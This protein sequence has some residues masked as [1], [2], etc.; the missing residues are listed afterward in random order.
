[1]LHSI[2]PGLWLLFTAYWLISARFAKRSVGGRTR[3]WTHIAIRAT[4]VVL[5]VIAIPFLSIRLGSS[6]EGNDPSDTTTRQAYDLLA[7]GFGPG[8][9]GPLTLVAQVPDKQAEQSFEAVLAA[10]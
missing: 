2:I 8:F 4:I 6:D 10:G 5:I 1:M 9:N 7:E 3:W